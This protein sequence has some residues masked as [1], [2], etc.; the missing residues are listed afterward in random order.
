MTDLFARAPAV[1][2][3]EAVAGQVRQTQADQVSLRALSPSIRE[4]VQEGGRWWFMKPGLLADLMDHAATEQDYRFVSQYQREATTTDRLVKAKQLR[5]GIIDEIN[6]VI[7]PDRGG[8]SIG[9]VVKAP[10]RVVGSAAESGWQEVQGGFRTVVSGLLSADQAVKAVQ[11][12]GVPRS[13]NRNAGPNRNLAQRVG[14]EG[15]G[16]VGSQST[17]GIMVGK[18]I[19]GEISVADVLRGD[20]RALGDGFLPEGDVRVEQARR[21]WR[22][23]HIGDLS[24]TPGRLGALAVAEPGTLGYKIISGA[25]DAGLIVKLDPVNPL[26]DGVGHAV[27]ARRYFG[28]ERSGLLLNGA[29]KTLSAS[30]ED[31]LKS[32]PGAKF[33]DWLTNE[34]S[35]KAIWQGTGRQM[36]PE[37]AAQLADAQ[38]PGEVQGLLNTVLG[39]QMPYKPRGWQYSDFGLMVREKASHAR[40]LGQMPRAGLVDRTKPDLFVGQIHD[41]LLNAKVAPEVV[42]QITERAIRASLATDQYDVVT[43]T[44]DAIGEALKANGM[45]QKAAHVM[46]RIWDG[47]EKMRAYN[48]DALTGLERS[49]PNAVL[50]GVTTAT[51]TP[52]MLE[53][54]L[55]RYIPFP[56]ASVLREIRTRTGALSHLPEG[57]IK[58]ELIAAKGLDAFLK[59]WKPLQLLRPAY[60][61]RVVGD[62]QARMAAS[63]YTSFFSHPFAYMAIAL[64]DDGKVAK[65]LGNLDLADNLGRYGTDVTG[66]R[67][68]DLAEESAFGDAMYKTMTDTLGQRSTRTVKGRIPLRLRTASGIPEEGAIEAWADNLRLLHDNPIAQKLAEGH[69]L[70]DVQ[71]WFFASSYRGG[72]LG[73]KG[74][75]GEIGPLADQVSTRAGAD[76]YVAETMRQW[77]DDL[78]QG[79]PRL[80]ELVASGKIG[81][82]RLHSNMKVSKD[83]RRALEGL[84]E[85]GVGPQYVIGAPQVYVGAGQR[86]GEQYDQV[87]DWVFQYIAVRPSNWASRSPTF[88][89]AYWERVE[90][91]LPDA[92]AEARAKILGVAADEANLPAA[93][94]RRLDG[95]VSNGQLEL[96]DVNLLAS[97]Y[98]SDKTKKL[99]YDLHNRGQAWDALRVA[100]P[101]GEAHKEVFTTWYKLLSDNPKS[102][103]TLQRT[104]EGARGAGFFYEDPTTGQEVFAVPGSQPLVQALTGIKGGK[105]TAPVGGLSIA[106]SVLP[107]VGPVVQWAA[108][109]LLPEKPQ[110]DAFRDVIFQYG[111]EGQG[112]VDMMV[113]G[114]MEKIQQAVAGDESDRMFNNAYGEVLNH[115][116]ASGD[117]DLTDPDDM[118]RLQRHAKSKAKR[119]FLLRGLAQAVN[120]SAPRPEIPVETARGA[121]VTAALLDEFSAMQAEDYETAYERFVTM[122]G[123]GA[124]E[125]VVP[126]S[127]S[128]VLGLGAS[129]EFGDFE[130]DHAGLFNKY[131]DVAG[132]FAP[133]GEGLDYT[134]YERQFRTGQRSTI[135]QRERIEQRNSILA[136]IAYDQQAARIG[137]H[138]NR[139]QKDWL[140]RVRD[141]LIEEFPGYNPQDFNPGRVPEQI[142]HLEAAANEK[143]LDDS[144][145]AQAVRE[146]MGFRQQAITSTSVRGWQ[147]AKSTVRLRDWL[148]QVAAE[149]IDERPAFAGVWDQLLSRELKDDGDELE[150]AA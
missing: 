104:V 18:L 144:E 93:V 47:F 15:E 61:L 84:L 83:G 89:Q 92:S 91:L 140:A 111:G 28:A 65:L 78:T 32:K 5:P 62:E 134:V 33:V 8:W 120:P 127:K 106:G 49:L 13:V 56:D 7:E 57:A 87:I 96:D 22:S 66:T 109:T 44:F 55:G 122:F 90:Q 10:L 110:F 150:A 139:A 131:P 99:L 149:I 130:R 141:E 118:V 2:R 20:E 114:W 1:R 146:Y 19:D 113:P 24:L 48:I 147:T 41:S 42:D 148:R 4:A 105:L 30:V 119:L 98:A 124:V 94:R 126:R 133:R 135:S 73:T 102:L 25:I 142:R 112:L 82:V 88:K 76:A 123:E 128:N 38:T 46:T 68:K 50:N 116:A 138:P 35:A 23:A 26:L 3:T 81:D 12:G 58:T 53:Q 143:S 21:A 40:W 129:E 52:A 43:S 115:L 45:D 95:I 97:G 145:V 132:L 103:R 85:E 74:K 29:R 121:M 108:G 137:E 69:S 125:A 17:F 39:F 37:I 60:I 54:F 86:F 34:T 72:I 117:Y 16:Y 11:A 63:G 27:Q 31:W 59:F 6:D 71:D 136:R 51:P 67:F 107:G 77:I 9:D 79:D 14:I 64:G 100:F 36:P 80:I 70:T 101:F 75:L